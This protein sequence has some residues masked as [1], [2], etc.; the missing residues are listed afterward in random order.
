MWEARRLS[1]G[2]KPVQ[3]EIGQLR[4]V[5]RK[6]DRVMRAE[7]KDVVDISQPHGRTTGDGRE[8]LRLHEQVSLD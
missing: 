2:E 6:Q 4:Q 5:I 1:A 8:K 7:S 3:V